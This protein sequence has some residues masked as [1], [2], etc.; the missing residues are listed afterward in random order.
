MA[1][2]FPGRDTAAM[3]DALPDDVP[4]DEPSPS[5]PSARS[6]NGSPADAER[7]SAL[8]TD[9]LARVLD[10]AIKTDQPIE[11]DPARG[12]I[13]ELFVAAEAAGLV[14]EDSVQPLS[15]GELTRRLGLRWNLGQA[16]QQA[17]GDQSKLP[18]Q[19]LDRVRRLW[20]LLRMWLEWSYAWRRWDE[21]HQDGRTTLP[22]T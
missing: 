9:Q 11:V 4:S 21:F 17:E 6:G 8:I 14:D 20:S 13:F 2:P 1:F 5:S 15:S 18:P 7:L 16:M 22:G 12:Q 19:E 10:E 3:S